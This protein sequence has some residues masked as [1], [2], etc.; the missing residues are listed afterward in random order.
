[1]STQASQSWFADSLGDEEVALVVVL[2]RVHDQGALYHHLLQGYFVQS[3]TVSL[4][5]AGDVNI[6]VFQNTP[7]PPHED[8]LAVIE[9]VALITEQFTGEPFPTYWIKLFFLRLPT[10]EIAIAR[11]KQ[12]VLQGGHDAPEQIVR[13]RFHA[14]LRNFESIY[15]DLVD[16]WVAY[17][18]RGDTPIL[19]VEGSQL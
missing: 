1:M 13:R 7:F 10:P 6:R 2:G 5:L 4:P 18:N 8:L 16:E 17:D 11:V 14:G 12:R 19:L 9:D 15:R 3:K